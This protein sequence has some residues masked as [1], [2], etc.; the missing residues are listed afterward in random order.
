MTTRD[1]RD[2]RISQVSAPHSAHPLSCRH[3]AEFASRPLSLPIR[4]L[5]HSERPINVTPEKLPRSTS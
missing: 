2:S 1:T 4:S 5:S 3:V